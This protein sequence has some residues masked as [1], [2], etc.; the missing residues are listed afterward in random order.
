MKSKM[1]KEGG[2][3][4]ERRREEKRK[5]C[6]LLKWIWYEKKICSDK[7]ME[8]IEGNGRRE[9]KKRHPSILLQERIGMDGRGKKSEG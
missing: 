9:E 2:F 8:E 5:D 3:E 1:R 7:R 4:V 6:S